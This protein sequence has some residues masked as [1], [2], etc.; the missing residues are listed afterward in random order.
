MRCGIWQKLINMTFKYLYCFKDVPCVSERNYPWNDFHC[1]IDSVI[2]DKVLGLMKEHN[3]PDDSHIIE[4]I[5]KNGSIGVTWNN[6]SI[7]QY[8]LTQELIQALCDRLDIPSK[9]FF[10]FI[11][12]EK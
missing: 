10:D 2:A 4:S 1:P 7:D 12:W 11:F 9:L 8:I 3:I 5:S 6:S